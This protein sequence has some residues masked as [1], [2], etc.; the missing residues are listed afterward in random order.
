MFYKSHK[1]TNKFNNTIIVGDLEIMDM[2][3]KF[4][5]PELQFLI[6]KN[7]EYRDAFLTIEN[8][9]LHNYS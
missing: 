1:Q 6:R 2:V 8:E 7:R 5:N 9:I 3:Y 4:E